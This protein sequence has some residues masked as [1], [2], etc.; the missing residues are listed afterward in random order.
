MSRNIILWV[1]VALVLMAVFNSF[2]PQRASERTLDYSQFIAEVKNA[3]VD[4]VVIEQGAVRGVTTGGEKFVVY[5]PEDPHMIDDL[6]A[7]KVGIEV[8]APDRQSLLMQVFI[9]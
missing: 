3:Q 6:L 1:V 7:N 5:T 4:R 2:G 8:A 9:S